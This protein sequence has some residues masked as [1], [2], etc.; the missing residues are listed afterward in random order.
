VFGIDL[1]QHD[2]GNLSGLQRIFDLRRPNVT[3][4]SHMTLNEALAW[5]PVWILRGFVLFFGLIWGSF[6]NVVIYRVP[7][8]MSVVRPASHC[9]GCGKPIA[10]YDNVP[11]FGYLLLRG[12]ARCCGAKM[13]PRYP[14]VEL[15][16]GLLSLAIL[17]VIVLQMPGSTPAVRALAVYGADFAL[18]LGLVAAAFIDA[19]HMFLP[20]SIT[21]GGIVLGIAT[22]T[23]RGLPFTHSLMGAVAGFVGVWFPFT[24]LYKRVLGRTGMG[25]GDAKLLALGGAWFGWEGAVFVLFAGAFQGSLYALAL[26]I[27]GIEHALPDAVKEDIE[28]LQKDAEAGDQ[29]AIE[30][31][32]EDPLA[33]AHAGPRMPFGPFLIL[34]ILELLFAGPWITDKLAPLFGPL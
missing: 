14:L 4:A 24:F 20:D 11:V 10:G 27:F 3:L 6:L 33:E 28:Q 22:A 12:R 7:R 23:L 26:R 8:D 25:L 16:G 18:C 34:A 19:E 30:A 15:I 29:E 21:L 1:E 32:A 13:S 9:P 5:F 17:E 31:L 2:A